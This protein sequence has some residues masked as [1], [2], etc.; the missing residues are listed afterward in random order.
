[1]STPVERLRGLARSL[2]NEGCLFNAAD[3]AR[4]LEAVLAML[5]PQPSPICAGHNPDGLT[6]EQVGVK[7]GWRLFSE[8]EIQYTDTLTDP[9][10]AE[11]YGTEPIEKW[12]DGRWV[13]G[14]GNYCVYTYRTRKPAGFY[15]PKPK[16]RVPLTADDLPTPV[17]WMRNGAGRSERNPPCLVTE[18]WDSAIVIGSG[19]TGGL[20]MSWRELT[21]GGWQYSADRKVWLPCY[22]EV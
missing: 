7:E 11:H 17:C 16:R 5:P 13:F 14:F 12:S 18:I 8:A 2:Q 4:D 9:A 10:M 19:S 21:D 3:V 6:E 1:M 15:L 20:R 22:K